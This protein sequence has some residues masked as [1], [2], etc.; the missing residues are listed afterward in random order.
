LLALSHS[1][2]RVHDVRSPDALYKKDLSG[3][4]VAT[5]PSHLD[6]FEAAVLATV[7]ERDLFGDEARVL[8]ALSGGADSV[9]LLAALAA[10][11][12][13]GALAHLSACHVDHQ[14]RPGSAADGVACAALCAELEVSLARAPV[15][16]PGGENVQQ[17]A[18]RERYRALRAAAALA[19]ASRIATGH[20]RGDQAETVL[21]RLLRGAG[22]RG[23]AGIPPR[24]G[25]LVR[26]LIDSTRPEIVAYLGRRGLSWREDPSNATPRYARNRVRAEVLPLLEALAPGAEARLARAADLLRDDDRALE[27]AAARLAPRGATS[28]DAL[29]LARAPPA[30]GR[31]AIRR[32]W[33]ATS[34]S[35]R[36]LEAVHVSAVLRLVRLGRAGPVA[37]PGGRAAWRAGDA[38]SMGVAPR[39]RGFPRLPGRRGARVR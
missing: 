7:R 6:P 29:R 10:L 24:R 36:G 18:R 3:R 39:S 1:L 19:G 21:L 34:G 9:A 15:T 4:P 27:R 26:P 30:V 17:A 11:R 14:L 32:L 33:R 2:P 25:T 12:G 38:L 37:L 35:R 20:T 16:V 5:R 31:R 28:A 8:V 23:L 13:A 22:A